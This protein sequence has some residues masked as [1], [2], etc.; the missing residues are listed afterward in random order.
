MNRRIFL[1][2]A[3]GVALSLAGCGGDGKPATHPVTVTVTY[4]GQPA[5]GALVVFHPADPAREKALGGKP[6]GTVKADGTLSVTTYNEGDGAPEG[7]YGVTVQWNEPAKAS[8]ISLGEE[9]SATR[10]KL[11]GRYGD[12]RTPKFRFTVKK[13]EPNSLELK[14]D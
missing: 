14:L 9:G 5:A 10:D 6:F 12:P 8:K 7:D 3:A 2:L 11:G 1:S 4:K 13:G